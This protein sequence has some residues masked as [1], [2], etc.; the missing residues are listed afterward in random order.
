MKIT[1]IEL[2]LQCSI[3]T[4]QLV[5]AFILNFFLLLEIVITWQTDSA[6]HKLKPR[7]FH[8]FTYLWV[9]LV[10][11]YHWCELCLTKLIIKYDL[12]N[13]EDFHTCWISLILYEKILN[14][15]LNLSL[16][17][18]LYIIWI[19]TWLELTFSFYFIYFSW[20]NIS[21]L[22]YFDNEE[23]YDCSY[24]ICHIVWGHEPKLGESRLERTRRMM[25]EHMYIA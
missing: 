8:K 6:V 18:Y 10:D 2:N 12:M 24:M 23:A 9:H 4:Y 7:S 14:S 19:L 22:F 11:F 16:E 3:A 25:L 21:F 15:V 17:Y 5:L 1:S 20:F 13:F